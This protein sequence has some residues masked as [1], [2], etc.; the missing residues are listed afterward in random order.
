VN[1][2][3]PKARPGVPRCAF[4]YPYEAGDIKDSID[5]VCSFGCS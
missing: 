5:F 3:R 1:L 4:V 2:D